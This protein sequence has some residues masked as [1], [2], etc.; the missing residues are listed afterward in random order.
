MSQPFVEQSLPLTIIPEFKATIAFDNI[1]LENGAG[2]EQ[3]IPKL[4]EYQLRADLSN[5]VLTESEANN[6]LNFFKARK[7][8]YEGFRFKFWADY[9]ASHIPEYYDTNVFTQGITAPNS[10]FTQYQLIKCYSV[11]NVNGYKTISKPITS[12]IQVFVDGSEITSGFTVNSS[13]G[14]IT[15]STPLDGE[16]AVNW[17]G[18]F[19]LAVRFDRDTLPKLLLVKSD[20]SNAKAKT[21]N[22]Q[23]TSYYSFDS[24]PIVEEIKNR[25]L[26]ESANDFT[27]ITEEFNLK[28]I[29]ETTETSEFK[30]QELELYNH[31]VH[32]EV[33]QLGKTLTELNGVI[34]Q[35]KEA[36]YLLTWYIATKG[37]LLNFKYRNLENQLKM[38]RFAN[39][40]LEISPIVK[41][42]DFV[43]EFGQV[44]IIEKL[45]QS[46]DNLESDH[47]LINDTGY[48][49]FV[50][51]SDLA[52]N[53]ISVKHL[54]EYAKF[55]NIPIIGSD[56]NISNLELRTD[57]AF[58]NTN[59]V[60]LT[61]GGSLTKGSAY[62]PDPLSD[63]DLKSF[64]C[65]FKFKI[66]ADP[67]LPRDYYTSG[68]AMSIRSEL[69]DPMYPLPSLGYIG[70][71]NSL[72]VNIDI[73]GKQGTTATN[74]NLL[75]VGINGVYP[76]SEHTYT[77]FSDLTG[78]SKYCWVDYS[79]IKK[80]ISVYLSDEDA[81]PNTPVLSRSVNL[82]SSKNL[83]NEV[84][85]YAR[86]IRIVRQ[87][88]TVL[89]FTTHDK[90]LFIDGVN[91]R[92]REA[93]NPTNI[94]QKWD[95]STNNSEIESILSSDAIRDGDILTGKY[96]DANVGIYLVN[97]TDL[98][99]TIEDSIILQS[100]IVGEV[101]ATDFNYTFEVV[102]KASTLLNRK[103]SKKISPVCLYRFGDSDCGVNLA[104]YTYSVTVTEV[105]DSSTFKING[106]IP[107]NALNYGK[108]SFTSGLNNNLD[109]FILNYSANQ[110]KLFAGMPYIIQVGDTL[111]VVQGCAKTPTACKSYNN[112]LRFGGFPTGGNFMPGNDFLLHP[113][114]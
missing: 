6:I 12:T 19:E 77:H 28:H 47:I 88:G 29:P 96:N 40:E 16:T 42:D 90:D 57:A 41:V 78:G 50:A 18:E 60:L 35:P 11:G 84:L 20:E 92:A 106:T 10:T 54:I 21:F 2:V 108:A 31:T 45:D 17:S 1:I 75:G 82:L 8:K 25:V 95:L 87:D 64:E 24:L 14:I 89:G 51:T 48:L 5:I 66:D 107:D 109:G 114:T 111:T 36:K 37:N 27:E 68:L 23:L 85:S 100:G 67:S 104:P 34:V 39:K 62:Y 102:S 15:F 101:T 30:T 58:V 113:R 99:N 7:G 63:K 91:Y 73:T 79:D 86:C 3:R 94:E 55:N 46:V 98:P 105:I 72:I 52:R 13:T 97:F 80:E 59:Q 38:G 43:L 74:K 93:V 9:W 110:I 44:G 4:T 32:R 61:P 103:A 69:P 70:I 22:K 33:R 65:K 81:K 83:A 53:G 76:P 26:V 56:A 112:Y 71:D 49:G